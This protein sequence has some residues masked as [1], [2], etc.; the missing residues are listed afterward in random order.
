MEAPFALILIVVAGFVLAAPIL[1]IAA[2]RRTS[3]LQDLEARLEEM[4]LRLSGIDRRLREL[5]HRSAA[6][7]QAAAESH[8][9]PPPI[10]DALAELTGLVPPA[11]PAARHAEPPE[12]P[13]GPEPPRPQEPGTP[14]PRPLPPQGPPPIPTTPLDPGV[15]PTPSGPQPPPP[16]ATAARAGGTISPGAHPPAAPSFTSL[17]PGSS[18]IDWERW[19]GIRGAAVL[20]AIA[21]GL[22]GLL[23][24]RYSIEHGLLTPTMRVVSGTITGLACIVLSARLRTRGYRAASEG[25]AGAGIVILY[26]AFWAAHTLY[27]LIPL[28]AAFVLMVLV[29]ATCCLLSVR[30]ESLLVAVLGLVGG[31]ATPL[32]LSS[33]EDR[34]IGLFGYILLLDFGLLMVGR[35]RGWPSLGLLSL[36][37]TALMQALWI[38]LRMGPERVM[39]GLVILAVFAALFAVFSRLG[40]GKRAAAEAPLARATEI[41]ALLLPFAFALYFAGRVDLGPHLYPVALLLGALAAGAGFTARGHGQ[42]TVDAGAAAGCVAVVFVWCAQHALT[43]ALSWEVAL[44]AVGLAAIFH[45]FVELEPQPD[46]Q[47]GP[48]VAGV[49]AALGLF[50]VTLFAA[51]KGTAIPWPWLAGW[52][53]LTVLLYRHAAFPGRAYLQLAAAAGLGIGLSI[54]HHAQFNTPG[55]PSAPIVLGLFAAACV[56]LQAAALARRDEEAIPFAE[57]SAALLPILLLLALV[58]SPFLRAL[59]VVPALGASLVLGL[60]AALAATRLGNGLWYAAAVGATWLAQNAWVGAHPPIH[61]PFPPTPNE[62]LAALLLEAA[63]VVL[64]TLWPLFAVRRFSDDPIAWYAAALCG[65]LWFLSLRSLYTARFGDAAI[66]V[67][68]ILLGALALLAASQVRGAWSVD[69][70]RRKSAL[71]W[72]AAVALCFVAVAIPLQLEKQWVT[73]GWAL[74]GLAVIALWSRLDHP[75]LKYFGLLLLGAATVRLVA[76]PALL[77]YY[78]RPET[79]IVNWLMYTYLVPWAAL[80]GSAWLLRPRETERARDWESGLYGSGA[81]I[82]A[83]GASI[84]AIAVL[85]VWMNLAIAD[86]YST[87]SSLTLTFGGT[88]A[89][90]LTVSITWAI[91]AL[92][93]LGLGMARSAIGLRWLSL[94]FLLVTIGKVFLYDLGELKDLYRVASLVGLAVS[95]LL[96][97]LLYQ[98]FVFRRD[99]G[100]GETGA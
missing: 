77:T 3:R 19:L 69:D 61:P 56:A 95:L 10:D 14:P 81:P 57:R 64:L 73:I 17:P 7:T 62:V 58:P 67:L 34:P 23:F 87:G 40:T 1:A 32:L 53:G 70:P 11:E 27:H 68:P 4:H 45:L 98:R 66:G 24:F 35:K 48:A 29:T 47:E 71:A 76:N 26:A 99:P 54:F 59:P 92:M 85:F 51:S 31:F 50:A 12:P 42:H 96:V 79:R 38:G 5:Q 8:P 91:Y 36:L 74:Q 43:T 25:V 46:G 16:R 52:G 55:F 6:P 75:G 97:S 21:L 90:R 84:S 13:G 28:P 82:G 37:A 89:Q 80:L 18:G 94:A 41:A 72:F 44:T 93:L 63:T 49:L 9:A 88:Q 15:P 39:L 2:L 60:L 100:G 83:A 86:W 65:P 20:G 30:Q 78:P 22:A 33:G